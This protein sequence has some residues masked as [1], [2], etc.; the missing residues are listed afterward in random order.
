[1]KQTVVRTLTVAGVA[2]VATMALVHA[3]QVPLRRPP[4][5]SLDR[6]PAQP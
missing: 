2:W 6:H 3:Q 1:M 4:Q 5:K